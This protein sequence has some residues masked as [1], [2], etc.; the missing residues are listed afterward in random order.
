MIE[1]EK[2]LLKWKFDKVFHSLIKSKYIHESSM[3]IEDENGDFTYFAG[4]GGRNIDSPMI[5]TSV[6][7]LFT[8]TC[9]LNL[10]EQG[11]LAL[12]DKLSAF[13]EPD[14]LDKIHIY[15]DKDY[16]DRLTV[17]NLLFQTTGFPDVF[18]VGKNN[19]NKQLSKG[20]ITVSFE[21]YVAIA[22][23]NK[24]KFAPGTLGKAHYSDLNFEMLGKIIEKLE[25]SSLHDAYK[26]YVFIPLQLEKT[27]IPEDDGYFVPNIYYKNNSL[28]E[29]NT[30]R[31]LPACGGC[32]STSRETMKF[33]KAFFGGKLF[34][35]AV[36]PQ[37]KKF[38]IIQYAPP[39]AQYGGGFVRLNIAGFGNLFRAKGQLIGHMGA[40]GAF[41]FYYPEKGLY[42]VG[43]VNQLASV[44]KTFIVPVQLANI[45]SD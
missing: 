39:L 1:K 42:F 45:V 23:A 7:K 30:I 6:S 35:K 32:I 36:F 3:H 10:I 20:D 16:S 28:Y 29:P 2:E 5:L 12:E 44:S 11:K 13:F 43:D 27:Y 34:D 14:V 38:S 26:K 31:S 9:I 33:L 4:H 41:A 22:K 21:D 19:L 17:R 8:T 18:A 15:K 40:S 25:N 24:K 37:L